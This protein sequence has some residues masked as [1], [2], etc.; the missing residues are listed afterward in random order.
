MSQVTN[1]FIY[2][3]TKIDDICMTNNKHREIRKNEFAYKRN[4]DH[5]DK[6]LL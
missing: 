6:N 2:N 1:L 3:K 4:Q 5:L